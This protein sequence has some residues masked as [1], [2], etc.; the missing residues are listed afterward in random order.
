MRLPKLVSDQPG[1][2][3]RDYVI[4][5]LRNDRDSM[6]VQEGVC[7]DEWHPDGMVPWHLERLACNEHPL[8]FWTPS[9]LQL[10]NVPSKGFLEMVICMPAHRH[11]LALRLCGRSRISINQAFFYPKEH[12]TR[13]K[14]THYLEEPCMKHSF[15]LHP[16]I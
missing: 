14:E 6:R 2:G 5:P 4:M 8:S 15:A 13:A 10:R 9:P 3:S 12:S 1:P 11:P 16:P 7:Q